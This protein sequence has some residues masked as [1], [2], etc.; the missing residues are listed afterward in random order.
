VAIVNFGICFVLYSLRHF[1]DLSVSKPRVDVNLF[2]CPKFFFT[3][4]KAEA[5]NK[6]QGMLMLK[7][8]KFSR[9]ISDLALKFLLG[10]PQTGAVMQL[11]TLPLPQLCVST[12][13]FAVAVNTVLLLV[14]NDLCNMHCF[15]HLADK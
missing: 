2:L 7:V 12:G 8:A 6:W 3:F 15:L 11:I 1:S 5:P 4:W 10:L 9:R 14:A 13:S